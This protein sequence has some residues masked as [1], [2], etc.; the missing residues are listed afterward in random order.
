MP[1]DKLVK[2][3]YQRAF[4]LCFHSK[5][6]VGGGGGG[7]RSRGSYFPYILL[8][9]NPSERNPNNVFTTGKAISNGVA[10]GVVH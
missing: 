4:I 1:L 3:D 9:D 2:T 8:N 7:R 10:S 5:H 6:N